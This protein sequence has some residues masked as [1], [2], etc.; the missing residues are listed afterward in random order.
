VGDEQQGA[1]VTFGNPIACKSADDYF[2]SD[3]IFI[4]GGNPA[5]TQIP[6]CH[7]YIEARYHGARVVAISPDSQRIGSPRRL[8]VPV[9]PAQTRPLLWRWP[10]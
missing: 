1:A 3:L 8:V 5:Y 7:F 9:R 6:N 4:W 10:R 2:H